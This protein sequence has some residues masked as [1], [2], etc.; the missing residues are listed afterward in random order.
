MPGVGEGVY[1]DF[2]ARNLPVA[3]ERVQ[4]AMHACDYVDALAKA[5]ERAGGGVRFVDDS[6]PVL[7]GEDAGSHDGDADRFLDLG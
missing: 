7:V 2:F 4:D 5:L 6:V 3:V 1:R